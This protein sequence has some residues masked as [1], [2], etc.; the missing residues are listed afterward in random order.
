M[1]RKMLLKAKQD[2]SEKKESLDPQALAKL[3]K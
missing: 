1:F 3:E 2:R